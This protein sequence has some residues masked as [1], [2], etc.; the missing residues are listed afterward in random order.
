MQGGSGGLKALPGAPAPRWWEVHASHMPE[1]AGLWERLALDM[2]SKHCLVPAAL[3][4][5]AEITQT[6]PALEGL[7]LLKKGLTFL[8]DLL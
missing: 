6:Q 2:F 7:S 8:D 5:I 1:G 4:R 3:P